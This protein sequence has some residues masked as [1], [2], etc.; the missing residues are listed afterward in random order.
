[1]ETIKDRQT[2]EKKLGGL[3]RPAISFIKDTL[4]G[5]LVG[6]EIGVQVAKNAESILQTLNIKKLY[7]IDPY[8]HYEGNVHHNHQPLASYFQRAV[9]KLSPFKDKIVWIKKMSGDAVDDIPDNL[10]FVYIDGNHAYDFVKQDL[11]KYWPKIRAGGILSG[12]DYFLDSI[13]IGHKKIFGMEVKEAVDEFIQK[14]KLKLHA[15][16]SDWWIVK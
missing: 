2:H 8:T 10:D 4:A 16:F 6:A 1:M 9:V 11:E 12:H 3:P 5:S 15:E 13:V 7:L 14:N